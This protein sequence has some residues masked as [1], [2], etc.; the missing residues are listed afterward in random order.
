MEK[1]KIRLYPT[2]SLI[3]HFHARI[4]AISYLY[5]KKENRCL[6]G[7]ERVRLDNPLTRNCQIEIKAIEVIEDKT[8]TNGI[9]EG[10]KYIKYEVKK[11]VWG[12]KYLEYIKGE[13]FYILGDKL[14]LYAR[15]PCSW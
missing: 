3:H 15:L 7:W 10:M 5:S 14:T 1:R 13:G 4:S 12:I 8:I 9:F 6:D 11:N 2:D